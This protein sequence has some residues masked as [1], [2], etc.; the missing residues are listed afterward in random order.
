MDRSGG[1]DAQQTECT[2]GQKIRAWR[3]NP[4]RQRPFS[5]MNFIPTAVRPVV[6]KIPREIEKHP[7]QDQEGKRERERFNSAQSHSRCR[8]G[9]TKEN[10]ARHAGN[11]G[12]PRAGGQRAEV[13]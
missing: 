8:K 3:E 4:T 2:G 13:M 11:I 10:I 9:D 12:E 7:G 1:A 5:T 6:E